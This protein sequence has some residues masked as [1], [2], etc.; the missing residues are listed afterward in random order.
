LRGAGPGQLRKGSAA[1]AALLLTCLGLAACGGS[2]GGTGSTTTSA[3]AARGSLGTAPTA[4]KI[5]RGRGEGAAA[6]PHKH[7]PKPRT[8]ASAFIQSG[9]DNSIPEYGTESSGSQKAEAAAALAAYLAARQARDW[10][11]A[12]SLMGVAV[13][14]QLGVLAEA[15]GGKA[16]NCVLSYRVVSKYGSKGE[17]ADVLI[18]SLAAFRV[19]GEKGFALFYGPHRQQF[20][21]PM[22]HEGGRWKVS[23]SIPIAYP[24]G[25]PVRGGH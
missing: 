20:M 7:Q 15:S 9:A 23:Q 6:N 25:A 3:P 21:M 24:I 8:P 5:A 14:R 13:R 12:C 17:R 11:R 2:S 16:G 18:G 22:V 19:K 1:G 4:Q 10:G